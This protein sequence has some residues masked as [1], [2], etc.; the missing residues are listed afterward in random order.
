MI[1]M[2]DQ[3]TADMIRAIQDEEFALMEPIWQRI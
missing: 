3:Q 2:D 1:Y